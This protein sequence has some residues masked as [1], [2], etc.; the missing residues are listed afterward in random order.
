MDLVFI[1]VYYGAIFPWGKLQKV[2]FSVLFEPDAFPGHICV[3]R[4]V[5][6]VHT[7]VS[8]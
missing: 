6:I 3:I 1:R 7:F 4:D 5:L 8:G 2:S